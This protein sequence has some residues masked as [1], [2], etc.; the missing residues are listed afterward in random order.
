MIVPAGVILDAE[1]TSATPEELWY[2]SR[3]FLSS[4]AQHEVHTG[5]RQASEL[6]TTLLVC[7]GPPLSSPL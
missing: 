5:Y 6:W 3:L 1:L 4:R 2:A 7:C